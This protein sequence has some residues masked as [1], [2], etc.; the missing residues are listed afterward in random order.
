MPMPEDKKTVDMN[1][2]A[3]IKEDGEIVQIAP[4]KLHSRLKLFG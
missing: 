2:N 3:D 1:V 4:V